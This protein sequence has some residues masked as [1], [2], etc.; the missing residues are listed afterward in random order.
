MDDYRSYQM[1][2]VE[3]LCFICGLVGA[4]AICGYLFYGNLFFALLLPFVYKEAKRFYCHY[5]AESRRNQLLLQFRDFL[6]SLSGSFAAGRH[7]GEALEEA[8]RNLAD[9]YGGCLM[10]QEIAAMRCGIR[11]TGQSELEAVEAFAFRSGL[12]DAEDFAEVFGACRK[13][14]GDMV[15]AVNKAAAVI[16]EKIGVEQ[17]IRTMVSQKKLEGRIIMAMP[18]LVILFLQTASPDYLAVMY[19]TLAGRIL[20]TAALG[21]VVA[22]GIM[23]ERITRI[24]I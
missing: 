9:I 13:T 23:I 18:F 22:A 16:G 8:E 1:K 15:A 7:M 24:D 10:E 20:M 2:P 5:R 21:A 12:P 4:L 11:E 6:Y 14:G 17:E 3:E 19:S